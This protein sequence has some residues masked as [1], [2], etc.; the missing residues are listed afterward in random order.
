MIANKFTDNTGLEWSVVLTIGSM[1]RIK[2]Q[3]GIDLSGVLNNKDS[4]LSVIRDPLYIFDMIYIICEKQ[5]AERGISPEM[6]GESIA[7]GDVVE[8]ATNCMIQ[9]IA[10]FTSPQQGKLLMLCWGALKNVTNETIAAAI[11]EA[12]NL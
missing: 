2:T 12:E 9:A 5:A 7:S 6:F 8:A 4:F 11:T 1:R 3:L 10:N